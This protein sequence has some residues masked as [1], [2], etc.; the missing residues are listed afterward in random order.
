MTKSLIV[1]VGPGKCGST[2]IQTELARRGSLFDGCSIELPRPV[3]RQ[4]DTDESMPDAPPQLLDSASALLAK[5][6]VAVLSYEVL[7]QRRR[8]LRNFVRFLRPLVDEVT[9]VGYSRRQSGFIQ[10]AYSQWMFRSPARSAEVRGILQA[11]GLEPAHFTG[12]EAYFIAAMKTDMVSARQLADNVILDWHAG[13]Q[14]IA[15]L[16]APFDVKIS[17]GFIPREGY[18]FSLLADFYRRCGYASAP[19]PASADRVINTQYDADL[20]EAV[21]LAIRLGLPVPGPH[22]HNAFFERGVDIPAL[23]PPPEGDELLNVLR[24]FADTHYWEANRAFCR[25]HGLSEDYF[26]P[27]RIVSLEHA[28]DAVAREAARR[29][30]DP[31][32]VSRRNAAI[33]ARLASIMFERYLNDKV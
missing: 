32:L 1:H 7:F 13:Y 31:D 26:E 33:A 19:L 9:V 24:D 17:A 4:F 12:L 5:G 8:A 22:E 29:R 15:R 27:R 28:E 30:A 21:H 25:E 6:E 10:S 11:A 3:I 14:D 23:S 20:I 18:E 16:L 2:S